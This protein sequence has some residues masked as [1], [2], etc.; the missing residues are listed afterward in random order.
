MAGTGVVEFRRNVEFWTERYRITGQIYA[1]TGAGHSWRFSDILNKGDR[2]FI[3]VCDVTVFSLNSNEI[4]WQGDFLA[5]N[6]VFIVL[7]T[8]RD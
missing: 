3:P 7:A 5:L 8:N 6:K 1:P 2:S 4:V